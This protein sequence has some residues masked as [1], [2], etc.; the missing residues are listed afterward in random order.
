[1][2]LDTTHT[3]KEKDELINDLVGK[4]Y[5]FLQSIRLG[6]TGSKRMI[7]DQVSPGFFKVLNTVSDLNYGNIE[8]REKGIVVHLTK[9]LKSFSWAIP[10]YQLHIYS[11]KGYSIHAQGNFVRFKKDKLFKENKKFIDKLLDKKIENEKEYDFY[12]P[13]N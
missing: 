6:G 1:M 7:V 3:N 12:D 4:S 5:S 2:I 11:T 13:I 10:Y 8:I 9:G